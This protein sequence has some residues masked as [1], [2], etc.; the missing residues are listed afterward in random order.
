MN[1]NILKKEIVRIMTKD[2]VVKYFG[3]KV[4]M[5]L[6]NNDKYID[7]IYFID[8]EENTVLIGNFQIDINEIKKIEVVNNGGRKKSIDFNEKSDRRNS[9][10]GR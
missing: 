3:K 5:T 6:K 4:I 2:E 7:T 9:K 1:V 10:Q 8:D